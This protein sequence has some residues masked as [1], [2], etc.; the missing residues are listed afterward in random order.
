MDFNVSVVTRRGGRPK[1]E[2]RADYAQLKDCALFVLADGMGGHPDG[3]V[4]AEIATRTLIDSFHKEIGA[5]TLVSPSEFLI[6]AFKKAHHRIIRYGTE[7]GLLDVPR[8][9]AV[10]C[11]VQ[12]NKM[13]WGNCGDSRLY[14]VRDGALKAC[15]VDHSFVKEKEVG[16]G[17]SGLVRPTEPTSRNALY[18]CLGSITLP[19]IDV[20][21][22]ISVRSHDRLLLCSDGLWSALSQEKIIAVLGSNEMISSVAFN[23]VESA[24]LAS[25]K[26]SDNVTLIAVECQHRDEDSSTIDKFVGLQN[27]FEQNNMLESEIDNAINEINALLQKTD[28]M[29][30]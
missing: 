26:K 22:P 4:A 30:K 1:N 23:L 15:T 17:R 5:S 25:G 3:E 27:I 19:V 6:T 10:A 24:L 21:G 12:N 13:W 20:T 16:Y 8:T 14:L 2:D 28:K 29:K 7:Q 9:T 18:T 11:F